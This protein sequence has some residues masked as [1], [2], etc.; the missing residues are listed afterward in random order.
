M[1][2]RWK[3][4][5]YFE[6][7]WWKRYLSGQSVETYLTWKENYWQNFI[8]D[9]QISIAETDLLLDAGCG[10]AG[11]FIVYPEN[12]IIAIDPLIGYYRKSIPHFRE[13]NYPNVQFG[14]MPIEQFKVNNH[15]NKIFC[16]NAI[17]HVADIQQSIKRLSEALV[18]GGELFLSVDAHNHGVLKTLFKWVP[19][20]ILHPHQFSLNEYKQLLIGAGIQVTDVSLIKK[21]TIFNYYLIKGH[22]R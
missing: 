4:A 16:L 19:G 8:R 21:E 17:N 9:H 13:G 6:G 5:Q 1:N 20:D 2:L 3:L 15:F 12:R 18:E 14:T 11:I 10:P 22:K 7:W